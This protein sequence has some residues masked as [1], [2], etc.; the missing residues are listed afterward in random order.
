MKTIC[1]NLAT[2]INQTVFFENTSNSDQHILELQ[3]IFLEDG[4]HYLYAESF[5]EGRALIHS[6]LDA[7]RCFEAPACFSLQVDAMDAP[8]LTEEITAA[9]LASYFSLEFDADFLWV[10]CD[11]TLLDYYPTLLIILERVACKQHISIIILMV[12]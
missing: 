10:E 9:N 6:Y 3:D 5:K 4:I 8:N 12:G 11:K 2:K 7:L 1:N